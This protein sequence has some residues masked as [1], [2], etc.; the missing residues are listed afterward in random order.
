MPRSVLALLVLAALAVGAA[1][2]AADGLDAEWIGSPQPARAMAVADAGPKAAGVLQREQ[3]A[4]VR[5]G[6]GLPGYPDLLGKRWKAKVRKADAAFVKALMGSAKGKVVRAAVTPPAIPASIDDDPLKAKDVLRHGAER[7]TRTMRIAMKVEDTCPYWPPGDPDYSGLI[8]SKV[9]AEHVVTTVERVGRYD[10]TTIVTF[11]LRA[12]ASASA[13]SHAVLGGPSLPEGTVSIVRQ[14]TVKDR[15][16]GKVSRRPLQTDHQAISPLWGLDGSFDDFIDAHDDDDKAPAPRRPLR[17]DVWDDMAQRFIAFVYTSLEAQHKPAADR[18]ATT[19][20][21]LKMEVDAPAR[22]SPGQT[23]KLTPKLIPV[24]P[25]PYFQQLVNS[26]T[27]HAYWVDQQGAAAKSIV[28]EPPPKEGAP[29]F[30]V[31]APAE[32]WP[33]DRP[34]G[35]RIVFTSGAG[36]AETTV[37]FRPTAT[38]PYKYKV[39]AASFDV[40]TSGEG[41]GATCSVSWKGSGTRRFS[42]S[43]GALGAASNEP[44]LEQL[45]S[46]ALR[47]E[48]FTRIPA[49]YSDDTT[50]GC[51]H[52]DSFKTVP[53]T[54]AHPTRPL[55]GDGMT[56]I[57]FSVTAASPAAET[58]MLDWGVP[59]PEVGFVDAGDE[60][61]SVHILAFRDQEDDHQVVPLAK[62]LADGPQTFE[63]AGSKTFT[64]DSEDDPIV[65]TQTWHYTMT[66]ERLP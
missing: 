26:G 29:W 61:C 43:P 48:V 66:V 54:H 40:Y 59:Q 10:V 32:R 65:M 58:A 36:V 28:G 60:E 41:M 63:F 23:I 35:I 44:L 18:I 20:A 16:T 55:G 17:S 53:C 11:E 49:A 2:A 42:S 1:P 31:T 6:L 25:A 22:L 4:K 64:I 24:N 5:R 15:R 8:R 45:R 52:D 33:E 46:G 12:E 3:S 27:I 9:R 47:G 19:N 57:G 39:T 14:Q 37:L 50:A 62:L 21:C 30:E 34:F 7:Q 56:S 13:S 51:K 38:F